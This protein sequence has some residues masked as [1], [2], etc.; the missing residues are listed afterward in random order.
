MN[1]RHLSRRHT[2]VSGS[3]QKKSCAGLA[4]HPLRFR[5]SISHAKFMSLCQDAFD[6]LLF[7]P[8]SFWTPNLAFRHP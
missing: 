5:R 2:G 4:C 7:A 8:F 1:C 3:T 6:P